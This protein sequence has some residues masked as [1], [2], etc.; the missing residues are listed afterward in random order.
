MQKKIVCLLSHRCWKRLNEYLVF[1]ICTWIAH[2]QKWIVKYILC[3]SNNIHET[4]WSYQRLFS[5]SWT[6]SETGPTSAS[7]CSCVEP[8]SHGGPRFASLEGP[9]YPN[10]GMS[11]RTMAGPTQS[12]GWLLDGIIVFNFQCKNSDDS[13]LYMVWWTTRMSTCW[14][15]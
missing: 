11:S 9:K 14:D 8:A 2:Q 6:R 5:V 3:E 7:I 10:L 13:T 12:H 15:N 1:V 4:F